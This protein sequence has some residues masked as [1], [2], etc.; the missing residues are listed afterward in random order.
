MIKSYPGKAWLGNFRTE[1]ADKGFKIKSNTLTGQPVYN[2]GLD[3]DDVIIQL[4]GK[5]VASMEDIQSV[6]AAHQPGDKID[7]KYIHREV[8]NE[9]DIA[10]QEDPS[11]KVVTY[12]TEGKPITQAIQQYRKAWL[13]S[14]VS[15]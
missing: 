2:A 12:E 3:Y 9:G 4:D 14:T 8:P 13:D 15:R 10:L 7:V 1:A 6:L 11:L 5:P